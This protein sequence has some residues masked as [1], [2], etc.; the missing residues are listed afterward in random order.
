MK[1]ELSVDWV[2]LFTGF[3]TFCQQTK[4]LSSLPLSQYVFI[5]Y[6]DSKQQN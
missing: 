3:Q 1:L 4:N 5:K 6:S 2:D